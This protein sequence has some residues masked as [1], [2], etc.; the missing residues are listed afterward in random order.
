MSIPFEPLLNAKR[1]LSSIHLKIN[2]LKTAEYILYLQNFFNTSATDPN[3][4][5][6]SNRARHSWD[7]DQKP[8]SGQI[9]VYNIRTHAGLHHS[10]FHFLSRLLILS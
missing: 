9:H 2:L 6:Q 10:Q 7:N 4:P 8:P 5:E 3:K 1:R